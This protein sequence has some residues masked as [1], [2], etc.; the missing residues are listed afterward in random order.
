AEPEDV[1]GTKEAG[2]RLVTLTDTVTGDTVHRNA[3]DRLLTT[4]TTHQDAL[5]RLVATDTAHRDTL[6]RLVT[7]AQSEDGSLTIPGSVLERALC[8]TGTIEVTLDTCGTP[9]DLG[10]EARLYSAR[11]KL[12]MAV[13]DGGCLW[14]GCDRPPAYCEAHHAEHWADGGNTDCATGVLL[15]R[16]HHLHLHN[17]GWRIQPVPRGAGGGF[18]LHAPPGMHLDPI[19]LRSKSSLRWLWDPP[20]PHRP[21]WRTAA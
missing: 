17:T 14:P 9:L 2:I 13:R 1:Y 5:G 10:R 20:P 11:Q 4:D 15:C 12:V 21:P 7:T 3:F 18:V 19:P 8:A 16:Y 6:G